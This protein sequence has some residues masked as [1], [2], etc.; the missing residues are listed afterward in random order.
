MLKLKGFRGAKVPKASAATVAPPYDP[1]ADAGYQQAT[2]ILD[3]LKPA[4]DKA[5]V[6]LTD[7]EFMKTVPLLQQALLQSQLTQ[8]APAKGADWGA[9]NQF[10]PELAPAK[11]TPQYAPQFQGGQFNGV[12]P[13]ALG[14]TP[15]FVQI[16]GLLG[17]PQGKK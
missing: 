5:G 15:N 6:K 3:G 17:Q 7:K 1:T 11:V 4:M 2:K 9:L 16:A 12:N 14:P 10:H 13:T 8:A